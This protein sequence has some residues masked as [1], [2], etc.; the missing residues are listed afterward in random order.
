MIGVA[1]KLPIGKNLPQYGFLSPK[2]YRTGI[3]FSIQA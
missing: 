2:N 3:I 1:K